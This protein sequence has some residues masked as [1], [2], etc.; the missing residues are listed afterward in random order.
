MHCPPTGRRLSSFVVLKLVLRRYCIG[1][2]AG[3]VDTDTYVRY[4]KAI[5]HVHP[6]GQNLTSQHV[7][8][9]AAVKMLMAESVM[10]IFGVDTNEATYLNSWAASL[11]EHLSAAMWSLTVWVNVSERAEETDRLS[12]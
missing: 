9:Q 3:D 11:S 4:H 1:N 8:R 6:S 7:G 10:A 2:G 5:W 12:A